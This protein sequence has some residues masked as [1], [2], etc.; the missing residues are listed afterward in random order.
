[1]SKSRQAIDPIRNGEECHEQKRSSKKSGEGSG[2]R[3]G[4]EAEGVVGSLFII[5]LKCTFL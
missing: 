1:M 3:F 5:A 2:S 4:S